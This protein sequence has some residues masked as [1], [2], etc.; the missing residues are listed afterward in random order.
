M[1]IRGAR[2]HPVDKEK[3]EGEETPLAATCK[4]RSSIALK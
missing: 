1:R 4:L 3:Q 2:H